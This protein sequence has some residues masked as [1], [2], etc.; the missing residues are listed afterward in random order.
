MNRQQRRYMERKGAKIQQQIIKEE[1]KKLKQN[2]EKYKQDAKEFLEKY[3][4]DLENNVQDGM[5]L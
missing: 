4:I 2:P 5:Q 3:K 1:L